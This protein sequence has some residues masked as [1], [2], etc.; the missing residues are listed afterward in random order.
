MLTF[1][2]GD[3]LGDSVYAFRVV[4]RFEFDLD[5]KKRDRTETFEAFRT[6]CI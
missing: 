1:T 6:D 5:D 3:D 2:F 4:P